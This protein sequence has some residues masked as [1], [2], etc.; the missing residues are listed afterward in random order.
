MFS[1]IQMLQV[2]SAMEKTIL[3]ATLSPTWPYN[4]LLVE[5]AQLPVCRLY[6]QVDW[7]GPLKSCARFRPASKLNHSSSFTYLDGRKIRELV[8]KY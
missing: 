5:V 1:I 3:S 4:A 2:S 7:L 8:D 6:G